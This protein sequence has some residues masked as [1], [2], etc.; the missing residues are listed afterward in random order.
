[1]S[2]Q[3]GQLGLGWVSVLLVTGRLGQKFGG[4]GWVGSQIVM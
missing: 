2:S 1:M 3:A 4:S